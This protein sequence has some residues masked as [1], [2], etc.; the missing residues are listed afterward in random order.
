MATFIGFYQHKYYGKLG[1]GQAQAFNTF[2]EK[3]FLS[4]RMMMLLLPQKFAMGTLG[5]HCFRYAALAAGQ[6]YFQGKSSN[7]L[8]L[9]DMGEA[10][11]RWTSAHAGL[12][13]SRVNLEMFQ[14]AFRGLP[15]SAEPYFGQYLSTVFDA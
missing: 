5:G 14:S 11:E 8:R 15:G 3:V 2:L 1:R 10:H 12:A 7:E 13:S 9:E 6:F 4:A